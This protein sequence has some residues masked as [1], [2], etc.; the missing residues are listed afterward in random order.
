M[1]RPASFGWNPQT[2]ASNH[3]QAAA[4]EASSSAGRRAVAEFDSVVAGL[5]AAG[6]TV[7]VGDDRPE[8]AC[9]DAVFPNNWVS[10][11]ADG[12]VVLYPMLAPCRR[13]ERRLDLVAALE[14]QGGYRVER[15]L[16]LTHHELQGRFLEGTGSVVFDHVGRVAYACLS[17]R[18]DAAVLEELCAELDYAPFAFRAADRDG[19]PVY[20][21]NVLLAIGTDFALVCAPAVAADERDALLERLARDGRRVIVIDHGQLGEFAGNVLEL[22]AADGA[23]VLAASQRAMASL[24]PQ[25]HAALESCVDRIVALPVPT[26]ETLGGGSVRCMLAEVFLPR[27]PRLDDAQLAAALVGAW[28]L[29]SWTIEYPASGRVTQPFGPEPEGL[30]VYTGDGH[31]SA[32]M[33]RPGRA[34]LS[35]ADPQAVSAD[36]KAAAFAAYLHYAGTWHVAGGCVVHEVT[37][38]MNPNLL[39]TRQVRSIALDGERLVLGA[40]ELLETPGAT[41]R[42]RIEWRRAAR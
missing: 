5:R 13:D 20:H 15:L 14:R 40:E 22:R 4:A 27:L 7:H 24:S 18:T 10:L 34:R 39:G 23:R 38:A 19:V 37:L 42:H 28:Q 21:T 12:T 8:P 9:P 36:E 16:D 31:M 6:V 11:H 32:A 33:Q 26:I 41:R 1:V 3:F 35:R 17:P 2:A 25:A 30:L 29:V